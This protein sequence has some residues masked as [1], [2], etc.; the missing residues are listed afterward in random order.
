VDSYL[1]GDQVLRQL[2][3]N[4]LVYSFQHRTTT[5][6]YTKGNNNLTYYNFSYKKDA[7]RLSRHQTV[8]S[9]TLSSTCKAIDSLTSIH[10]SCVVPKDY[11]FSPIMIG[12]SCVPRELGEPSLW[13]IPLGSAVTYETSILIPNITLQIASNFPSI[14]LMLQ[15]IFCCCTFVSSRAWAIR[16]FT[17]QYVLVIQ[18]KFLSR[19]QEQTQSWIHPSSSS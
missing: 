16:D 15:I 9:E 12:L 3:I 14:N 10:S 4:I 19:V 7:K 13:F 5:Y 18:K 2:S 8:G 17:S 11:G 6:R 1:K